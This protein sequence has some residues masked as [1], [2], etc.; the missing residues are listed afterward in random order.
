MS[1]E[2]KFDKNIYDKQALLKTAFLFTDRVYLH[3]DQDE[4]YWLVSWKE[5]ESES[6]APESFENAMIEQS[7]HAQLLRSTED[8]RK[9]I[10]ARA[11]ASTIM[12]AGE[13]TDRETCV[14]DENPEQKKNIL[15]GWFER[16]DPQL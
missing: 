9:L 10:L 13:V 15:R 7:L 6:L 3:L 11:F 5:K 4:K 8:I 12:E 1:M 16:A 2:L 14:T